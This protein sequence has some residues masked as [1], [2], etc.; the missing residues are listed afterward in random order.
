MAAVRVV[1]WVLFL[2]TLVSVF[3]GH[4]G[5]ATVLW[6]GGMGLAVGLYV[7]GLAIPTVRMRVKVTRHPKPATGS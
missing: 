7:A 1:L 3:T 6:L 4:P 5:V 2:G